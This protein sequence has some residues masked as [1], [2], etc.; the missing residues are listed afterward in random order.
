MNDRTQLSSPADRS[1]IATIHI[2]RVAALV[3][4]ISGLVGFVA[5]FVLTVEKFHILRDPTYVPGCTLNSTFSCTSVMSS[6]QAGLFGFPNPLIGI[7]TFPVLIAFGVLVLS[8]GRISRVV[9]WGLQLGSL[10]GVVFAHWLI[11]Q[12]VFVIGA[13]CL[14]CMAAWAAV[15][16]SFC[17]ITLM[18]VVNDPLRPRAAPRMFWVVPV[19]WLA[20]IAVVVALGS[21]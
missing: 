13:L 19:V 3:L 17:Y 14:Y 21:A 5:S 20:G 11:V 9:W 1:G 4:I 16:P 2:T 8:G 6:W 10:A 7:A 18:T 15:V 12:S